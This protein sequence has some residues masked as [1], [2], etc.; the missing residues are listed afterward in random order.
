MVR[1]WNQ[2]DRADASIS[3]IIHLSPNGLK[4]LPV[5]CSLK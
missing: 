2:I 1:V 4:F 5:V 3:K